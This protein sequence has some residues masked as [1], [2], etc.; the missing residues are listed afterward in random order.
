M[1]VSRAPGVDGTGLL[2]D[3]LVDWRESN[4]QELAMRLDT[5]LR[6]EDNFFTDL[7]GFQM[8]RRKRT[9]QSKLP[10]QANFYP[11][12]S[13]AYLQGEDGDRL[14]L[15]GRQPL[16]AASLKQGQMEVM[17]D[18]RLMQDDNRGLFQV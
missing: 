18:R 8:I 1:T 16:G 15:V 4:N 2:I 12:P 3:N 10:L 6:G 11:M 7:N 14:T 9:L 13:M 17:L 5:D